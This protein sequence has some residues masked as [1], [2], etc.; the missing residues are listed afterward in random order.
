MLVIWSHSSALLCHSIG[1]GAK[2]TLVVFSLIGF[3]FFDIV[4]VAAIIN[5]VV[6]S[7]LLIKLL[8]TTRN[9]IE[10]K[11]YPSFDGTA[12]WTDEAAKVSDTLSSLGVNLC[13]CMAS[14]KLA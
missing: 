5:Y 2:V 12:V 4:Y 9:L 3:I 7:E 14:A 8:W 1:G 6:Q 10:T 11:R 13:S